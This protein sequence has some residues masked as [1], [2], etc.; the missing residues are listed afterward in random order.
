MI[1]TTLL[2]FLRHLSELWQIHYF[3]IQIILRYDY[4]S[5]FNVELIVVPNDPIWDNLGQYHLGAINI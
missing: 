2:P 3:A 5:F 4:A 1:M